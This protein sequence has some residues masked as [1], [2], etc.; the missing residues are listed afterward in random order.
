MR[1]CDMAWW[2]PIDL[3][4][5]AWDITSGSVGGGWDA[6]TGSET[7][8]GERPDPRKREEMEALLRAEL[9]RES[10]FLE[11]QQQTLA[12]IGEARAALDPVLSGTAMGARQQ[13]ARQRGQLQLANLYGQ[14]ASAR[15]FG[16]A[17]QR[18]Q[19]LRQAPVLEAMAQQRQS[20]A[21]GHDIEAARQQQLAL[22]Q[23]QA[24]GQ[25]SLAAAEQQR[26]LALLAQL[27][28][29]ISGYDQYLRPGIAPYL[30]QAGAGLAAA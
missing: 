13:A 12:E 9:E 4:T 11:A 8:W 7:L 18:A 3:A 25:R 28:G 27:G 22:L 30:I 1:H 6:I 20:A 14:A 23:Q 2:N 16:G 26:R 21:A 17:G 10:P 5:D 15:G 24:T 29:Q 19:I